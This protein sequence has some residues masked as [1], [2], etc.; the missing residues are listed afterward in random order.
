MIS[1][2]DFQLAINIKQDLFLDCFKQA[3]Q[4]ST[5]K[6]LPINLI[7]DDRCVGVYYSSRAYDELMKRITELKHEI[8]V[9][10]IK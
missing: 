4:L 5:A 8:E 9:L 3:D 6:Q 10:K 7:K 1:N 2:I